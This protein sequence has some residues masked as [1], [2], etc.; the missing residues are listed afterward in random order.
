MLDTIFQGGGMCPPLPMPA[1]AHGFD[2]AAVYTACTIVSRNS[3]YRLPA[4]TVRETV[5]VSR[6]TLYM[7]HVRLDAANLV[8]AFTIDL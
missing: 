5:S 6:C 1:G 3:A 2:A 8:T 4:S 7:E